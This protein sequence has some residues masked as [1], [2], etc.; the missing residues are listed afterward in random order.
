MERIN[1]AALVKEEESDFDS[2][3]EGFFASY[4]KKKVAKEMS[5]ETK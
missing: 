2:G 3:E 5:M 1:L 4:P